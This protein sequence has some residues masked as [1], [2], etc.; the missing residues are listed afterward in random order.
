ME[1]PFLAQAV[2]VRHETIAAASVVER[3]EQHGKP[4]VTEHLLALA[5]DARRDRARVAVVQARGDVDRVRVLHHVHDGAHFKL[6][7]A[8]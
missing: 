1:Q 2:R 8:T 6:I 3:I 5:A 7:P 4:I